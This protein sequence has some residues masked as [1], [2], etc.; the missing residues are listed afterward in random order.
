MNYNSRFSGAEWFKLASMSK[1]FIGGVGS[2]GSWLAF[3]LARIVDYI[4]II[5]MDT[6]EAE[7]L[8]GQFYGEE[9][10]NHTKVGAL[11]SQLKNYAPGC[12][13]RPINQ[14]FVKTNSRILLPCTFSCFDSM[15]SR[16]DLLEAWETEYGYN[17]DAL[18]M[19]CRLGFDFY[20]IFCVKPKDIEQYKETLFDDALIPDSP[21]TVKNNTFVSMAAAAHMTAFFVN[22]LANIQA[23]K[24]VCM[25]PFFK[26]VNLAY[27][28]ENNEYSR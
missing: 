27:N 17:Q 3:N 19:D 24:Q 21:C 13:I 20:Q 28:L 11:H 16:K 14:R 9:A 1:C 12:T 18:F 7:N 10:I 8:G 2:T 15:A 26:E 5:D 6:V 22:H 4:T 23:G 25:V